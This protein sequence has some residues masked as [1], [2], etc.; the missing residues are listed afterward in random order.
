MRGLTGGA[1]VERGQGREGG[2]GEEGVGEADEEGEVFAA[3]GDRNALADDG[4]KVAPA[5][6]QYLGLV[7]PAKR[8]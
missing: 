1:A 2:G 6:G 5:G 7:S 8:A 4:P 3:F